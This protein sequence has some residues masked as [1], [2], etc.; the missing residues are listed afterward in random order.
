MAVPCGAIKRRVTFVSYVC[1]SML[2]NTCSHSTAVCILWWWGSWQALF[3]T[4][5]HTL[6]MWRHFTCLWAHR[7]RPLEPFERTLSIFGGSVQES[8]SR[9]SLF[10]VGPCL[11]FDVL[12]FVLMDHLLIWVQF[13]HSGPSGYIFLLCLLSFRNSQLWSTAVDLSFANTTLLHTGSLTLWQRPGSCFICLFDRHFLCFHI[14]VSSFAA[15]V[16]CL[17][18]F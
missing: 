5:A 7:L 2:Y 16:F 9:R 4:E 18:L 15:S 13:S 14:I 17:L 8:I 3:Q 6:A 10:E 11:A 1:F 12:L